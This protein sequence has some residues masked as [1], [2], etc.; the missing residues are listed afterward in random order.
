[1]RSPN[2]YN[3]AHGGWHHGTLRLHY[4]DAELNGNTEGASLILRRFN[5]TG[6][7]PYSA[8]SF[9]TTN[10]WVENNV[11]HNF[12]PWTISSCCSPT[13]ANGVVGGRITDGTGAPVAGVVVNL[14]GTQSRKMIT[15]A[16]GSY[17]FDN[18][19]TS[20]FYTVTPSRT[21]YNFSPASRSFTQEGNRTE[22]GFTGSSLG[23]SANPARHTGIL[24]AAAVCG[25]AR[26]RAGRSRLQLL[27]RSDSSLAV[28]TQPA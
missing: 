5:G 25:R 18:V 4:L 7:A 28:R 1:M 13:V 27:E 9:D 26:S 2:V 12:S 11:V 23:D 6:W 10:N 19:D 20:G 17:Q 14:S 3:N 16:N 15:D 22:A 8:T 21:N 24:C